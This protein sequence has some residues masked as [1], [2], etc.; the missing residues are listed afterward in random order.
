M[1]APEEQ[2]SPRPR[3]DQ[4]AE[5]FE[6]DHDRVRHE[7]ISAAAEGRRS[8]SDLDRDLDAHRWLRRCSWHLARIGFYLAESD[9]NEGRK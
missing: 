2:D 6:S 7:F 3:L 5:R 8:P 9:A 4:L 1:E